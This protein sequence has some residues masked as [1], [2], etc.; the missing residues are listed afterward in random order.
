MINFKNLKFDFWERLQ[1][2]HLKETLENHS[3]DGATNVMQ[4]F[5]GL[6]EIGMMVMEL[7]QKLQQCVMRA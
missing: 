4:T 2:N 6:K 7:W 3:E 1:V 5:C